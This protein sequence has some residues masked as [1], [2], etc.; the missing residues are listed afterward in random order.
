MGKLAIIGVLLLAA[1]TTPPQGD[2]CDV[3]KPVR[4]SSQAVDALSDAE[5]AAVLS[6]NRKGAKLCGWK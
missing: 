5:V 6:E 1:C 4:L 3:A 2:F